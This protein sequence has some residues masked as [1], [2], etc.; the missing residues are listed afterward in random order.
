[1]WRNELKADL[2]VIVKLLQEF[3]HLLEKFWDNDNIWLLH[4]QTQDIVNKISTKKIDISDFN[5]FTDLIVS[6]AGDREI[7]SEFISLADDLTYE[8]PQSLPDILIPIIQENTTTTYTQSISEI[9]KYDATCPILTAAL[10]IELTN[11]V[12]KTVGNIWDVYF[13]NER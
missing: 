1:M 9:P 6:D 4:R 5:P 11:N 2:V 12:Y 3:D 10:K 8:E 7:W 13:E